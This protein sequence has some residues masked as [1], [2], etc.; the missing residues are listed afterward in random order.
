MKYQPKLPEHNVNVSHQHPLRE[1]ALILTAVTGLAL[2]AFW[3]LG[4]AVDTAID[5]MSPQAEARVHRALS[6]SWIQ[7]EPH[8]PATQAV[9]EEMANALRDCAGIP[10]PVTLQLIESEQPN[11]AVLPGAHI[12]VFSGLLDR[13]Q[14]RNA[15]AFVLAH[16]LA[17]LKNRDHL[18]GLGRQII[19]VAISAGLTGA[20]SDLTQILIPARRLGMA[21][22]SQAREMEADNAALDVLKC[23]YGHVGGATEFFESLRTSDAAAIGVSHYFASHPELHARIDNLNQRIRE[24]GYTVLPV[25]PFANG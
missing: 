4:W 22:H 3:A 6:A 17:H 10:Y 11:A 19:L 5:H 23:H 1:F 13:V 14:S 12:L 25:R 8:A 20:H 7:E 24:R 21:R 18:R 16:E 2:A 9:L 15:V